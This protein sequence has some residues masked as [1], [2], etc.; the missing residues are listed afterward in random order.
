[1]KKEIHF[2]QTFWI[3]ALL[4]PLGNNTLM[5]LAIHIGDTDTADVKPTKV[6]YELYYVTM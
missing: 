2:K 3:R 4:T 1:M 6:H 5:L